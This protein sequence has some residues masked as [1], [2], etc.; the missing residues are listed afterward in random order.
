MG[1]YKLR[2]ESKTRRKETNRNVT[3]PNETKQIERID[4]KQI[5]RTLNNNK[6][7]KKNSHIVLKN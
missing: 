3:K 4:T 1:P 5:K 7:F 2:K 6:R